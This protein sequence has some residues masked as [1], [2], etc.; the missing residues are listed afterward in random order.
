[1]KLKSR[2]R[3]LDAQ[4][5]AMDRMFLA[6]PLERTR[7]LGA[8]E[9]FVDHRV[10]QNS[11]FAGITARILTRDPVGTLFNPLTEKGAWGRLLETLRRPGQPAHVLASAGFLVASRMLARANQPPDARDPAS[12]LRRLA[13]TI[14][15]LTRGL[16]PALRRALL[17]GVGFGL[18]DHEVAPFVAQGWSRADA[19]LIARGRGRSVDHVRLLRSPEQL[20]GQDIP[21]AHRAAYA[22]GVGAGLGCRLLGSLPGRVERRVCPALQG[23][24]RRGWQRSPCRAGGP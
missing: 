1:M 24:L 12:G 10:Y 19:R 14:R 23:A 22:E 3:G 8:D 13:G 15:P 5:A 21:A 2:V 7:L 9:M 16:S 6:L 20:C 17:E 11:K 4:Y 18:A